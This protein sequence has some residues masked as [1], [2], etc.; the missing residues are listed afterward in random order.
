VPERTAIAAPGGAFHSNESQIP[1]TPS[2]ATSAT[3]PSWST[4]RRPVTRRT[5]AAGIT[6][7][8][9]TSSAPTAETETVALRAISIS[10]TTSGSGERRPSAL[11]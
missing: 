1:T 11:A 2:S 4:I 6:K 5:V 3:D 10:S 8:A 9:V 7:S